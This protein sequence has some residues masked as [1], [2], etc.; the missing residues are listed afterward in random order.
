MRAQGLRS[1]VIRR[2]KAT[3]HSRHPFPVARNVLNQT[4]VA[5]RPNQPGMVD[6][7]YVP[8]QEGWLYLARV[9][10]LYTRK[11]VGWACAARM[12][13]DLT[14]R[15]LDRAYRQQRPPTGVLH[16]SDRGSP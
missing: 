1:R 14:V 4:F 15:A 5:N 7:T 16:H 9:E 6:I 12:T 2:Y 13:Q 8:T 3:T 10:D 11:I